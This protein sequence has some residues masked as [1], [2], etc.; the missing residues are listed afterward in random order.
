MDASVKEGDSSAERPLLRI[1]IGLSQS[2]VAKFLTSK[3]LFAGT[4]C[5]AY[6]V[7]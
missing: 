3:F 4:R 5:G 6:S 7:T 2:W 1:L